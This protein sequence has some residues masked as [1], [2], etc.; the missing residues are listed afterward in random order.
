LNI[1]LNLTDLK[2]PAPFLDCMKSS[3]ISPAC[4]YQTY[5]P[6]FSGYMLY[7]ALGLL[8]SYV[9]LDIGLSL[10]LAYLGPKWGPHRFMGWSFD[11]SQEGD[12]IKVKL[13]F[14]KRLLL[15]FAVFCL[16][17]LWLSWGKGP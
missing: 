5:C 4:I 17:I 13:W 10:I 1:S 15:A 11:F 7:M 8:V 14:W 16:G 6:Q 2:A 9:F 3:R 12:R